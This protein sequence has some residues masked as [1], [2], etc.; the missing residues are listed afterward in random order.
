[1]FGRLDAMPGRQYRLVQRISLINEE[2][3]DLN[4]RT[5]EAVQSNRRRSGA[6]PPRSVD[7]LNVVDMAQWASPSADQRLKN[8]IALRNAN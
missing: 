8:Y 5:L 4:W 6:K 3:A 1:M 2:T 7:E